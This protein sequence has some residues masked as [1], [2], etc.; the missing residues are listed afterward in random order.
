MS[1]SEVEQLEVEIDQARHVISL[2]DDLTKLFK[3]KPFKTVFIDQYFREEAIRLVALKSDPEFQTPERQAS[4]DRQMIG[5]GSLNAYFNRISGA[6][7]LA[8]DGIAAMQE[9]Q[10][11]ALNEED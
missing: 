1:N 5:I 6:A 4:I 10:S 2:N 7:Q 8:A 9:A 3:Y 11:E